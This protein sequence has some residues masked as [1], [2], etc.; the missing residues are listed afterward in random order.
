MSVFGAIRTFL[1]ADTTIGAMLVDRIRP[2]YSAQDDA[3]PRVV[4]AQLGEAE[5]P[6][7]EGPTGLTD[8]LMSLQLF[9]KK[10][11]EIE[12]LVRAIRNRIHERRDDLGA[13]EQVH[14]K[15]ENVQEDST[16]PVSGKGEPIYGKIIDVRVFWY[17]PAPTH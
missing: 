10:Q 11:S 5:E 7:F 4:S 9:A 12:T 1:L 2:G 14:T 15:L 13:Y 8:S 6:V 16:D 3:Y 17:Q